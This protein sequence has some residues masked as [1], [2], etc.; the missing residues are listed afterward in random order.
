M[1]PPGEGT[2]PLAATW[3]EGIVFATPQDKE[4]MTARISALLSQWPARRAPMQNAENVEHVLRRLTEGHRAP[5][6]GTEGRM[7]RECSDCWSGAGAEWK[8]SLC[9]F[10]GSARAEI[11]RLQTRLDAMTAAHEQLVRWG[12]AEHAARLA[13][14][15]EIQD[16]RAALGEWS[17]HEI[18]QSLRGAINNLR[19]AAMTSKENAGL[20]A[21]ALEAERLNRRDSDAATETQRTARLAAEG[22]LAHAQHSAL[23]YQKG[24]NDGI[25]ALTESQ[26]ALAVLRAAQDGRDLTIRNLQST[27][28]LARGALGKAEWTWDKERAIQWCPVCE[29][30]REFGHATD[31]STAAALASPG[32]TTG[33]EWKG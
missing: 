25:E 30:I 32:G 12:E 18:G 29:R 23:R 4:W 10:H 24:C 11:A 21:I 2:H 6:E 17:K 22:A 8:V 20:M 7:E 3:V 1:T 27:L 13:A 15:G 5:G 31:C 33:E 14:E 28:A 9:S 19:Q 16:A 26:A